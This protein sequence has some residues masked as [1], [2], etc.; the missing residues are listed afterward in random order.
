VAKPSAH[1]QHELSTLSGA[2]YTRELLARGHDVRIKDVL[3]MKNSTVG[4]LLA[5]ASDRGLLRWLKRLASR[6]PYLMFQITLIQ[7]L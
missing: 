5:S 4:A 1:A 6:E 3:R 7:G 2:A